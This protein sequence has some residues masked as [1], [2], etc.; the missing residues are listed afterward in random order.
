MSATIDPTTG[1]LVETL[2][3]NAT[4]LAAAFTA[5]F[6]PEGVDFID[7]SPDSYTG[8][9]LL[10]FAEQYVSA[11]NLFLT[12]VELL[13]PGQAQGV[14]VDYHLSLQATSRKPATPSTI[15]AIVYGLP[16][17]DV[18]DRRVR[19]IPNGSLWRTPVGL[20]IG[21]TG[22]TSTT[23]TSVDTGPINAIQTG[24]TFWAKVDDVAGW[25]AVES[26]GSVRLGSLQESDD[27]ARRR[28]IRTA[29]GIGR[30]TE[31][32]I[33]A[34]LL[35]TPG[36]TDADVDNNRTLLPNANGVS[37]KSIESIV[38]GGTDEDVARTIFYSYSGTAGYYGNTEVTTPVDI[39]LDDGSVIS[40]SVTVKFTRTELVRVIA[41]Y[42][43]TLGNPAAAPDNL[44][45]LA[46]QVA[47]DYINNAGRGVDVLPGA[48]ASAIETA[49][50]PATEPTIVGEV[51]YYGDPL[52]GATLPIS[53][54]QRASI[55]PAP[56]QAIVVSTNVQPFNFV[57][58]WNLDLSIDGGAPIV[59]TFATTDFVV[60]SAAEAIEVA[61]AIARQSDALIAGVDEGALE[62]RTTTS[63]AGSSVQI[64]NSS[65]ALLLATLGLSV[66]TTFGSD[67][68]IEIVVV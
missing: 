43:I 40:T 56:Q 20:V 16:G 5:A 32:A 62:L 13:D 49:L 31:P 24:T 2:G 33:I 64:L 54:R 27:V 7:L 59:F 60:V 65:S 26:A 44:V 52:A 57:V 18:G 53:S 8:R 68:D 12:F 9:E 25:S 6:P 39:E 55:D 61:N 47:A 19:F 14:W 67:G 3:D 63:G 29:P 34:A 22:E 30:A 4:V 11:Q 1:V 48:S 51:A 46:K 23:L 38:E 36:V 28:V 35:A 37:A 50:P 42:T 66:G 45:D 10:I 21:P 17:T 15:P 58:T 41:R